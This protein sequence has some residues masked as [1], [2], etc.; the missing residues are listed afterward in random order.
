MASRAALITEEKL[1][2]ANDQGKGIKSLKARKA[3]IDAAAE[4][5]RTIPAGGVRKSRSQ[6]ALDAVDYRKAHGQKVT[7]DLWRASR[8]AAVKR[9]NKRGGR[10]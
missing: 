2:M 7:M 5:K 10:R 3:A 1:V 6:V 4:S 9:F 8:P